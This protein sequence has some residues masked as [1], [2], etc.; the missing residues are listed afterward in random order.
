[1][2]NQLT[3]NEASSIKTNTENLEL[4]ARVIC[5]RNKGSL[6][7]VRI[8]LKTLPDKVH[9][10]REF[11]AYMAEVK[12]EPGVMMLGKREVC[13]IHNIECTLFD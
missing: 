11:E 10:R 4:F 12:N 13:A 9:R 7:M 6:L 1:M 2:K 3:D 8:N 5:T